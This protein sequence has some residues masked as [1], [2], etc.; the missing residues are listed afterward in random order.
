MRRKTMDGIT[1]RNSA[2]EAL[3]K[4]LILRRRAPGE[5]LT[6]VEWAQ[7]LGV[8]RSALREALARLHSEGLVV[9][10]EKCGYRI[11]DYS[12]AELNEIREVSGMIE[13]EAVKRIILPGRKRME[14]LKRLQELCDEIEW[15]LAKGYSV[16]LVEADRRFHDALVQLGDQQ[17]LVLL[18][19]C[20]PQ[21][22]SD[23]SE[24][25]EADRTAQ[26]R[27]MLNEHRAIVDALSKGQLEPAQMLIERHYQGPGCI[28]A[29]SGAPPVPAVRVG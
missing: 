7:R 23:G 21:T 18:H 28:L 25:C 26:A 9:E 12:T 20:L 22:S 16:E 3:R 24:C 1:E 11:P 19:R 10:G 14:H 13:A 15:I 5:K 17:R 6:E 2:Y 4:E 8:N 27:W 29:S